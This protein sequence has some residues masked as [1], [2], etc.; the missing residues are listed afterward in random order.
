MS[1]QKQPKSSKHWTV[2]AT[3][4]YLCERLKIQGEVNFLIT[5]NTLE[6][7]E[8]FVTEKAKANELDNRT[9]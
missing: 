7:F 6:I 2:E 9:V 4:R 3:A 1:E 5:Y 8:A